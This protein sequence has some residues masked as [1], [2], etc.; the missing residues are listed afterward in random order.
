MYGAGGKTRAVGKKGW[1]LAQN[2]FFL[3]PWFSNHLNFFASAHTRFVILVIRQR[4]LHNLL[5]T[6]GSGLPSTAKAPRGGR[7]ARRVWT[8]P[9]KKEPENGS[10]ASQKEHFQ[11]ILT[12]VRSLKC[13]AMVKLAYGASQKKKENVSYCLSLFPR[14]RTTHLP[15]PITS[16]NLSVF[17]QPTSANSTDNMKIRERAA[18]NTRFDI[19][20]VLHVNRN[21]KRFGTHRYTTFSSRRFQA[22][23]PSSLFLQTQTA[24]QLHSWN[25]TMMDGE[26]AIAFVPCLQKAG[27]TFCC[28]FSKLQWALR[29]EILL[30]EYLAWGNKENLRPNETKRRKNR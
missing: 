6:L 18:I 11:K 14:A 25:S 4:L 23:L 22:F 28:D 21:A 20:R 13:S 16:V 29:M 26:E 17:L 8:A 7:T 10:S 19:C 12:Y 3:P 2:L 30:L 1:L 24:Q 15:L 5:C 9:A 27:V